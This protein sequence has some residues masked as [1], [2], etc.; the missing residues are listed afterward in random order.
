VEAGV[1]DD[2]IFVVVGNSD[3]GIFVVVGNSDDGIFV[4]AVNGDDLEPDSD[5]WLQRGSSTSA[6]LD[7]ALSRLSSVA[8]PLRWGTS[9][10]GRH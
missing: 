1:S 10:S 5:A 8:T 6:S 9:K 4:V 7:S 3:D 2:G